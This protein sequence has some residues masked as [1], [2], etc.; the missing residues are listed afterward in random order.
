MKGG[1]YTRE[2]CFIC[3]ENGEEN[4][5]LKHKPKRRGCF[6]ET[7]K[8]QSNQFHCKVSQRDLSTIPKL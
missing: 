4:A 6:C 2:K 3:L 8:D 7:P 1:I 5:T